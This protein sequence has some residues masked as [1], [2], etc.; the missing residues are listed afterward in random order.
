MAQT[1]RAVSTKRFD[2]RRLFSLP[3]D[4]AA[5]SREILDRA[6]RAHAGLLRAAAAADGNRGD[7]LL[8]LADDVLTGRQVSR[9]ARS[10]FCDPQLV[11]ALHG[12]A[13]LDPR[14]KAWS[15]HVAASR[16]ADVLDRPAGCAEASLDHLR[17]PL[18]LRD[19]Q[20]WRG[21]LRLCTDLFGRLR[22]PSTGWSVVVHSAEGTS[23]RKGVLAR[24]AVFLD[25]ARNTA[26]WSL[27]AAGE[28][29]FLVMPRD[30]FVRLVVG[31]DCTLEARRMKFPDPDIRPALQYAPVLRGTEIRYDA[32][33]FEHRIPCAN[34]T[35]QVINSTLDAIRRDS[36]AMWSE[37]CFFM[38]S[39]RG[40]E[41]PDSPEGIVQSFSDPTLP[42][43]MS[44]NIPYTADFEPRLCPFF[45]TWFGHELG[46][47]KNYLIETIAWQNN[48]R[49]VE[50][51]PEMS[52]PVPRYNRPLAVRTL[53]QLPYVHLYEWVLLMDFLERQFRG[54]SW[55]I[56]GD[57]LAFGVDLQQEIEE[58]FDLI[59]T[60]ARLTPAGRDAIAHFRE[61]FQA[62]RSRWRGLRSRTSC[63]GR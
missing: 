29:S 22:F 18:R 38:R 15:E 62:V 23:K 6:A 25:V 57:P 20:N 4:A 59:A 9:I 39:V 3:G 28:P 1:G 13:P 5:P 19:D 44:L 54:F 10:L 7:P 31:D 21:R 51:G 42:G 17:L 27:A 47:T 49:F 24:E 35:G 55:T 43:V 37:L 46:H 36:P 60:S 11:E 12:L 26:R 8:R 58:S 30:E 16:L 52:D 14:L 34:L 40:F 53:F 63:V 45:F 48:C 50:N 61:L 2:I 56:D 41:L 32:I 33:H